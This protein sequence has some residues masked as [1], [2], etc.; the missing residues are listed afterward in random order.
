M[1]KITNSLL[2][3]AAVL[4]MSCEQVQTPTLDPKIDCFPNGIFQKFSKGKGLILEG[5]KIN[6]I[7]WWIKYSSEHT[8]STNVQICGLSSE[9]Q[10]DGIEIEF[11]GRIPNVPNDPLGKYASTVVIDEY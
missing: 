2:Y 10:I 9:L 4:C 8:Q 7:G 11:T 1:K 3:T 6:Q 5:K